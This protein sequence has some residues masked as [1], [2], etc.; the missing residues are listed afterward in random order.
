MTRPAHGWAAAK[1]CR[2]RVP[3][4]G[5]N[6][7]QPS[8]YDQSAPRF[9]AGGH[10]RQRRGIT[11]R[12]PTTAPVDGTPNVNPSDPTGRAL[13]DRITVRHAAA[14]LAG[15]TR[16]AHAGPH[17]TPDRSLIRWTPRPL[18]SRHVAAPGLHVRS[19]SAAD[20]AARRYLCRRPRNGPGRSAA[21]GRTP[22]RR[23]RRAGR[24]GGGPLRRLPSINWHRSQPVHHP[25]ADRRHQ[26]HRDDHG[27]AQE[28][29]PQVDLHAGIGERDA[30]LP[31]P[32]HERDGC[33]QADDRRQQ[34]HRGP[35][36]VRLEHRPSRDSEAGHRGERQG[37]QG[38]VGGGTLPANDAVIHRNVVPNRNRPSARMFLRVHMTASEWLP[39]P[40]DAPEVARRYRRAH[41]SSPRRPRP[42]R[43]SRGRRAAPGERRSSPAPAPAAGNLAPRP[44]HRKRR[45]RV[46]DLAV[47][48]PDEPE[49]GVA[50]L[51]GHH[52]QELL[53]PAG[54]AGVLQLDLQA[55]RVG[56]HT[57]IVAARR[58][59]VMGR[60]SRHAPGY[61][62]RHGGGV[63]HKPA[64]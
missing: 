63:D 2:H 3:L 24:R 1:E 14:T 26:R 55:A 12:P 60:T 7:Q 30:D 20:R 64:R 33:D 32:D 16:C 59:P 47:H 50:V 56:V 44:R 45:A 23:P 53:P 62:P 42:S 28:V 22:H 15:W 31:E 17:P 58:A 6:G 61:S 57:S 35:P 34:R 52:G 25:A 39:Q 46:P 40:D 19:P 5:V 27:A 18:P 29:Q 10:A 43:P 49:V 13:R 36:R 41:G 4:P 21:R 51:R 8:T 38:P 9:R 48:P 37:R 11:T 54:P